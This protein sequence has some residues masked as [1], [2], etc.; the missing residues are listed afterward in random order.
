LLGMAL[1]GSN[2]QI[3]RSV[4]ERWPTM[5]KW[6]SSTRRALQGAL[7]A[8]DKGQIQ[9]LSQTSAPPAPEENVPLLA[10]P[11][12][13]MTLRFLERFYLV[14]PI[15]T[16]FCHRCDKD[17]YA[18][19]RNRSVVTLRRQGADGADA[20]S[21][22]RQEITSA[23]CLQQALAGTNSPSAI[24]CLRWTSPRR[25]VTGVLANSSW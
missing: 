13:E 5:P 8:A 3:V 4:V 23:R 6:R 25:L 1:D 10:M 18:L 2:P 11:S 15:R 20:G 24:K 12:L 19:P 17:F 7:T 9:L 16:P 22:P 21:G 14:A